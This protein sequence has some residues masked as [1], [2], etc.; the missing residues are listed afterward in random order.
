MVSFR[1]IVRDPATIGLAAELLEREHNGTQTDKTD[2]SEISREIFVTRLVTKLVTTP[3][4]FL[5][6]PAIRP[7]AK[8]AS[9]AKRA[10]LG[11]TLVHVSPPL[12]LRLMDAR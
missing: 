4:C 6:K 8:T 5:D 2:Q 1:R 9:W 11:Y 10:T 3:P 7:L 12:G